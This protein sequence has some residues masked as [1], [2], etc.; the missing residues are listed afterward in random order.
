MKQILFLNFLFGL[1][2]ESNCQANSI[3]YEGKFKKTKL[4]ASSKPYKPDD[5]EKSYYD[6]SIKIAFPSDLNRHPEKYKGRLIHL[7]GIVDSVYFKSNN[8]TITTTVIL[9]NKFWDYMEDYSIQDEIMFIS[10]RGDGKFI[11]T[12]NNLAPADTYA[13]KNFAAEKKLFLVYGDFKENLNDLPVINAQKIKYV[14]YTLYSTNIFSYKI[15][16]DKNDEPQTDKNG[17]PQFTDFKFL[18]IAKAGQNK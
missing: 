5:W 2:L 14:D 15:A 1:S 6:S 13:M 9:E 10:P 18:K 11:V 16:R 17:K 12:M 8:D 3:L 7:I 4:F